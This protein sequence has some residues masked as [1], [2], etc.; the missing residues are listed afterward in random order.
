MVIWFTKWYHVSLGLLIDWFT[1]SY[2][3]LKFYIYKLANYMVS[4]DFKLCLGN[5]LDPH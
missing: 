1:T 4:F 3:V 2:H 5:Q